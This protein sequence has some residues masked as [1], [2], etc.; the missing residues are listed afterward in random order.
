MAGYR[1]PPGVGGQH[2]G[3]PDGYMLVDVPDKGMGGLGETATKTIFIFLFGMGVGYAL[4]HKRAGYKVRKA[5]R[6]I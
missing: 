1:H 3:V 2:G 5:L 6:S 4:G